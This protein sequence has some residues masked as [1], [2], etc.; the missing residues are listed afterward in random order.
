VRPDPGELKQR[1]YEM[2]TAC[3][4]LKEALEIPELI[5]QTP[6]AYDYAKRL[7]EAYR[8][9]RDTINSLLQQAL[10]RE[11]LA[12]PEHHGW[13]LER[14][15]SSDRSI[16]KV[17]A[18]EI[19]EVRECPREVSIDEAVKLAN[20]YGGEDSPRFVNGVLADLCEMLDVSTD[21]HNAA[22]GN[23]ADG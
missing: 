6:A 18:S 11:K 2:E 16:M 15:G 4:A 9:H 13:N 1:I 12:K 20:R 3:G 22:S 21:A 17:A 5:N 8:K 23:D 10:A 19:L 14:T 7:V